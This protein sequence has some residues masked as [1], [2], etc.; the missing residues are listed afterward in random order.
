LKVVVL[1]E[2]QFRGIRRFHLLEG[3]DTQ[4]SYLQMIMWN[5]LLNQVFTIVSVAQNTE[6]SL[7][8]NASKNGGEGKENGDSDGARRF[9][10]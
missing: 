4:Q 9:R 5:T 10:R 3:A 8:K 6:K 2:D 7:R 1:A